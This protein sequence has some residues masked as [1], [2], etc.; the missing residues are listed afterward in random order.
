V[1]VGSTDPTALP[2]DKTDVGS[3]D[4]TYVPRTFLSL[5]PCGP[6]RR[7]GPAAMGAKKEKGG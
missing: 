4:P 3:V 7:V 5:S 2:H 6:A 1:Q